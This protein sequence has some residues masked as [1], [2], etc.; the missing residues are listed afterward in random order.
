MER[1]VVRYC[2]SAIRL[3]KSET[4]RINLRNKPF[5]YPPSDTNEQ[6]VVEAI[7]PRIA[8]YYLESKCNA[9]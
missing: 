3:E 5:I 9:V 7:I 6:G 4:V 1:Y 8:S 2:I